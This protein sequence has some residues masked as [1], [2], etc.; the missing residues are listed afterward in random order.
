[1]TG[2][3][4][5]AALLVLRVMVGGLFL[6]HGLGKFFGPPFAG[7][8]FDAFSAILSLHLGS[9]SD[10]M[11]IAIAAATATV[12]TAGGLMLMAGWHT[13]TAA[14][15]LLLGQVA[16]VAVIRFDY[17]LFGPLGWEDQ[18]V[19]MGALFALLLGGPGAAA[20]ERETSRE[21]TAP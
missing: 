7:V 8:G 12:E 6:W 5:A 13:G 18:L 21:A 20:L 11:V 1:M 4:R 2:R 16:N 14:S 10:A 9:M 17:G 3:N 19:M 15:V